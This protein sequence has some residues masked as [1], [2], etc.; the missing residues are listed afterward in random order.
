M[1]VSKFQKSLDSKII[2]YKLSEVIEPRRFFII[3]TICGNYFLDMGLTTF[4]ECI[5]CKSNVNVERIHEKISELDEK[6]DELKYLKTLDKEIKEIL[7]LEL[8]VN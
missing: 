2:G 5:K 1:K 6:N 3:C 8:S 7:E 4:V